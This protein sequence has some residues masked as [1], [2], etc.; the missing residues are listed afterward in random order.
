MQF[1]E[2]RVERT[3]FSKLVF[4]I[5]LIH[6]LTI[7]LLTI[8][9]RFI[10]EYR[11]ALNQTYY[12]P[13][14][15]VL[16]AFASA[17]FI[18]TRPRAKETRVYISVTAAFD[19]IHTIL[20]FLDGFTWTF[21]EIRILISIIHLLPV[22]PLLLYVITVNIVDDPDKDN[23]EVMVYEIMQHPS[24]EEGLDYVLSYIDDPRW[25]FEDDYK[26]SLLEYL[27]ERDDE[28]GELARKKL[29]PEI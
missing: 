26:V 14:E 20:I 27:A 5:L 2:E 1:M 28:L 12:F 10:V 4:L 6:G 22:I 17:G 16:I 15:V 9:F 13:I 21:S 29:H 23:H 3:G 8:P 18:W 24:L 11:I 19:I 25:E 7:F